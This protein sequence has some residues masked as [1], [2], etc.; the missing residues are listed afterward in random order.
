MKAQAAGCAMS[1]DWNISLDSVFQKTVQTMLDK[2][3]ELVEDCRRRVRMIEEIICIMDDE[4]V[5]KPDA[6]L[7]QAKVLFR[8]AVVETSKGR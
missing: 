4:N 7:L 6:Y 1:P 3:L 2:L 8:G 5:L